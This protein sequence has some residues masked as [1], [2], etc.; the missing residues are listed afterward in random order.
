MI[1]D[2]P[3]DNA[4]QE[5]KK[6]DSHKGD[7]INDLDIPPQILPEEEVIDVPKKEVEE[8]LYATLI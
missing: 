8:S 2:E 3:L 6:E 4:K 1:S 7:E 5:E